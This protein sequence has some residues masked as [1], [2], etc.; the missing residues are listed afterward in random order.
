MAEDD[1]QEIVRSSMVL[2]GSDGNSIAP[3]GITSQGKPHPR[4]YGTFPRILGHYVRQL[5]LLPLHTA[6]YKMTGGSAQ[7]L[8]L[9]D[10]GTLREGSWADVTI[11][12]A[13][14]VGEQATYDDPHQYASGISTVLVNGELVIDEGEHTGAVPG[15]VLRRGPD[16]VQ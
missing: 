2:V 14:Q 9:L 4:F 5:G 7:A 10:R 15:R 13:E 8:R 1:V 16:G 6:I 12:D 3:Y 11:F